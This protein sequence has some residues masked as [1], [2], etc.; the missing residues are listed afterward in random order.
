MRI[1]VMKVL[2]F[3][4]ALLYGAIMYY[5]LW[6]FFYWLTPYVMG[7][8]WGWFIAYLVIGV[9]AMI[10]FVSGVTSLIGF[11]MIPLCRKC[12]AAKYAPIIF[13]L[14]FGYS[15]V[16]LPWTLDMEYGVLQWILGIS[17][18]ITILIAF[19]SLMV[20]PFKVEEGRK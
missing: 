6:L 9:V 17:F 1:Y 15:S 4:G 10:M 18:T 12:A 13:G 2:K 8:S 20:V 19:I 14:L 5:L 16:R 11:P 3:L 7:M